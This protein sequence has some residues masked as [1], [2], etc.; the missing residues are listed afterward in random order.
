MKLS[1][2]LA[3][4]VFSMGAAG[5]SS[6]N[7][8]EY[9]TGLLGWYDVS[10]QDHD[11]LEYG[12]EYRFES[13]YRGLR[14]IVGVM[15]NTDEAVYGYAGLHWDIAIMPQWYISPNFTAGAYSHGES[16]DLGGAIEFRSGVELAYEFTNRHRLGVAFNHRSNASI[17]DRNPGVETLMMTYSLPMGNIF[18]GA[19][20]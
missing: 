9:L 14:P 8:T 16:K 17:Y 10:Q 5:A 7:A 6:A 12:G 1:H 4:A 19:G 15:A 20:K 2:L 11:S 13:V 3:S 18:Y